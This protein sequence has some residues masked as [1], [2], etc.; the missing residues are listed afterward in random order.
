M[1]LG[2]DCPVC[3]SRG[4]AF[5]RIAGFTLVRCPSPLCGHAWVADGPKATELE[6]H[7]DTHESLFENAN[8]FQVL[9]DY[10]RNPDA[11]RRYYHRDRIRH[12]ESRM[13]ASMARPEATVLD[14][15]CSSGVFLATLRDRG[16]HVCGQDVA[17]Q[18]VRLGRKELGLDLREGPLAA[19]RIE[20]PFDLATCYDVI[21]HC[22]DPAALLAQI[23]TR[24]VPGGWLVVRTPNHSGWLPRLTGQKW[25][26]YIPPAHLHYF[27]PRSLA[28]L[29]QRT[30]FEVASIRTDASTYLY[31]IRH[32]L[33]PGAG[34][35]VVSLDVPAWA[36]RAVV[37]LD[38]G[39]RLLAWPLLAAAARRHQ[40]P[41]LEIYAR[42]VS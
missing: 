7:Y 16:F 29:L 8:A 22:E 26:W 35:G 5:T 13:A 17:V 40:N 42:T 9:D 23:R 20:T 1:A 28:A 4:A 31:L 25:L 24:L 14:V 34:G 6:K 32:Y 38:R 33:L 15:G 2:P 3:S 27:N 41:V 37:A 39:V 18:A 10:R 21:E 12:L 19:C 11:V 36:A 30:G